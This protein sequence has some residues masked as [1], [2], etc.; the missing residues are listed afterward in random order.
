MKLATPTLLV[1]FSL[2]KLVCVCAETESSETVKDYARVSAPSTSSTIFAETFDDSWSERWVI[3][4]HRDF[5][6]EWRVAEGS[7]PHTVKGDKGLIVSSEARKHAI[8]AK[9]PKVLDNTDKDIVIQYELRLQ[10][11]LDC[12]GAYIKLLTA[13]SLPSDLSQ[14][15]NSVPYTIMF[16][17]DKCG[18]TNKIHFIV[19]HKNPVSGDIEEKHLKNA[20]AMR[21]DTLTHLYALLIRKDNTFSISVDNS[22]VKEGNLL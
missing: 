3:T 10:K 9:F 18:S 12:G 15:S 2:L 11:E 4:K 22:V 8:S 1:L 6:G 14:F 5:Q 17:P 13:S 16:G 20:P 7:A 21:S 19:R